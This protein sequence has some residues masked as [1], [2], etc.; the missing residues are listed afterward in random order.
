MAVLAAI[1]G[2]LLICR[3]LI[4]KGLG[5]FDQ[6]IIYMVGKIKGIFHLIGKSKFITSVIIKFM[7]RRTATDDSAMASAAELD[8]TNTFVN[9][10][11][12]IGRCANYLRMLFISGILIYAFYL[13]FK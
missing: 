7:G 8:K 13:F 6:G 11:L 2:L 10:A 9:T 4:A 5:C 3:R 12:L 1:I